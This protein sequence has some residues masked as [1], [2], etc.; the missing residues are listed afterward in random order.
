MAH[1]HEERFGVAVAGFHVSA[2]VGP[3]SRRNRRLEER[4]LRPRAPLLSR[5]PGG[6]PPPISGAGP[7]VTNVVNDGRAGNAS[8]YSGSTLDS[9]SFVAGRVYLISITS[10]AATVPAP[11]VSGGSTTWT[12]VATV[13]SADTFQRTTVLRY[14]PA[15]NNTSS[16]TISF[17]ATQNNCAFSIEEC[18]TDNGGTNGSAAIVQTTTASGAISPMTGTLGAFSR[19]SNGTYAA[20]GTAGSGAAI[21]CEGTWTALSDVR[22]PSEGTRQASA[23]IASNDTSIS[24]TETAPGLYTLVGLE[25]AAEA[26]SGAGAIALSTSGSGAVPVIAES[27][28]SFGDGGHIATVPASTVNGDLLVMIAQNITGTTITT[29]TGWTRHEDNITSDVTIGVFYRIAFNEPASYTVVTDPPGAGKGAQ[30]EI[31]RITG[32]G[33]TAPINVY[34]ETARQAGSTTYAVSGATTTVANCL[35]IW[36]A[37]TISAAVVTFTDP[38]TERWDYGSDPGTASSGSGASKTIAAAGAAGSLTFTSSSAPT[39]WAGIFIAIAPAVVVVTATGAKGAASSA[40]ISQASSLVAT[41]TKGGRGAGAVSQASTAA[42]TGR[43]DGASS[44]AIA[45]PSTTAA[46]GRKDASA[47]ASI[48]Q[49]STL[50]ASATTTRAGDAAIAVS[51]TLTEQGH[52]ADAADVFIS[53]SPVLIVTAEKQTSGAASISQPATITAS[54]Q[55]NALGS[56]ASLASTPATT[57]SGEPSQG[58]FGTAAISQASTLVASG[59]KDTSGAAELA[60]AAALIGNGFQAAPYIPGATDARLDASVTRVVCDASA[61]RVAFIGSPTRVEIASA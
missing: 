43:K 47:P 30:V 24:F 37:G 8:S 48:S 25:L 1:P 15:S 29:P 60:V 46:T 4:E 5:W 11:T 18:I 58:E 9:I 51:S 41:R 21:T 26:H 22:A 39:A 54:G 34:A 44:A 59:R 16:L 52:A 13:L 42:A 55:K 53:S 19:A 61:T 40:A 33:L 12:Q 28:E 23:W 50:A 31:L 56:P 7:S 35:G 32:A 14:A 45:Q 49:A 38:E 57:A 27:E 10:R 36:V 17:S 2:P 20:V 3:G 6:V